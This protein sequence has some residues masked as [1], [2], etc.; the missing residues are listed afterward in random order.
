MMMAPSTKVSENGRQ[1]AFPARRVTEKANAN[2]TSLMAPGI[3]T[4]ESRV[5]VVQRVVPRS[6]RPSTHESVELTFSDECS[7]RKSHFSHTTM[8]TMTE[9]ELLPYV[10]FGSDLEEEGLE[11]C[12][13]AEELELFADNGA[14][15]NDDHNNTNDEHPKS[16]R[17]RLLQSLRKLVGKKHTKLSSSDNEEDPSVA[18]TVASSTASTIG[19]NLSD[20]TVI[21]VKEEPLM[22]TRLLN[23]GLVDTQDFEFVTD[24]V[25]KEVIH[26]Y[27]TDDNKDESSPSNTSHV[28][29]GIWQ[30]TCM[31][32]H[33]D[34]QTPYYIV[35]GVSMDDR[36][37]TKKLR[38]LV[39]AGQTKTHKRR[40]KL[41]MAPTDIAEQLAGFQSGTMAPICH[42]VDMK[43]YLQESLVFEK[44]LNT[45]LTV[46]RECLASVSPFRPT[47]FFKSQRQILKEYKYV[48]L[49]ARLSIQKSKMDRVLVKC[50]ACEYSRCFAL[51]LGQLERRIST[52]SHK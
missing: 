50:L 9:I 27:N 30:I 33:G 32:C 38:R 40:P 25:S 44:D 35:T 52:R 36:V 47:S 4:V 1:K 24:K 37:D 11:C 31:D 46:D 2:D 20:A 29:T 49:F 28:K 15:A 10:V 18:T 26:L 13:V 23:T 7:M 12:L 51:S 39:F 22:Q 43:L 19:S 8:T 42:S 5:G 41:C 3:L 45:K 48:V 34:P 21:P 17:K 16:R 6:A 14:S